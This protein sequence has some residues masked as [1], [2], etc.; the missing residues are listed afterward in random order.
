VEAVEL[1]RRFLPDPH[2]FPEIERQEIH[3]ALDRVRYAGEHGA[4]QGEMAYDDLDVLA[5]RV[6]A[7]CV[8]SDELIFRNPET[9]WLDEDPFQKS[10]DG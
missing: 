1:L 10:R 7:W 8:R 4:D 5:E 3:Q 2:V 6:V 9:T